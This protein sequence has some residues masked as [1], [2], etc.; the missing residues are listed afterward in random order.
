M[1]SASEPSLQGSVGPRVID[2]F[3]GAGLFGYGFHSEGYRLVAAYEADQIAAE[4][5]R[6]NLPGSVEITD[7]ATLRPKGRC[8]VIIAGPPCQGFSSI[9]QRAN[10]DPRNALCMVVPEWVRECRANVAVIENVPAFLDSAPW[11]RMRDEFARMNFD[12]ATWT[13]N[14]REYGVAQNRVRSITICSRR[15]QPNLGAVPTS[16]GATVRDAFA[17]LPKFPHLPIQHFTRQQS[18]GA[19][20]RISRIPEGGDI[21][22]LA[23]TAPHLVPPSWFRTEGKVVDIWGRLRWDGVSNTLRTGFLNP[24]RG[25]FLHPSEDRPISFR[26]AARLQGLPDGFAFAGL[27]EQISRQIGNGVPVGLGRAVARA[28]KWLF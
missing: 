14:A 13:L 5:H 3:S 4:T 23:R 10:N 11:K 24:S 7:L 22:H 6:L 18:V 26:E 17:G 27:P 28:V 9:G 21:R 2:L 8:D 25:R 16:P 15:D 19:L 1:I 12:V 20:D